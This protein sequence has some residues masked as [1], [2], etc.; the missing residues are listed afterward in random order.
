MKIRVTAGILAATAL[1]TAVTAIATPQPAPAREHLTRGGLVVAVS[2][3]APACGG[4]VT[5]GHR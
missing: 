1:L 2:V 5:R 3:P 4:C